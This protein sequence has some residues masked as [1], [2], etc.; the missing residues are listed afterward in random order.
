MAVELLDSNRFYSK[1]IERKEIA[2]VDFFADWCGPC[3]ILGPILDSL[4]DEF[5]DKLGFYKIN[6]DKENDLAAK[7]NI[8]SIPTVIFFK[9]GE[10]ADSFTGSIPKDKVVGFIKKNIGEK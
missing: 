4:S 8:M 10:K 5:N 1:I 2:I 6:V 9:G 3:K 7:Y